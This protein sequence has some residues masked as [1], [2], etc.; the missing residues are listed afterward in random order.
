MYEHIKQ[1]R[2]RW[3]RSWTHS[4]RYMYMCAQIRI[5]VRDIVYS[6]CSSGYP[7]SLRA[8]L[9]RGIPTKHK[10][11]FARCQP[12]LS[13]G[14]RSGYVP[15][16]SSSTSVHQFWNLSLFY[17]FRSQP[18]PPM[19]LTALLSPVSLPRIVSLHFF[20]KLIENEIS[21]SI[22]FIT[23]Q[24]INKYRRNRFLDGW[25]SF[26]VSTD[27]ILFIIFCL[28]QYFYTI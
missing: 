1:L 9:D 11:V 24:N 3:P 25:S 19:P 10:A 2:Y 17:W 4:Y 16:L 20:C 26:T 18:P 7:W 27:L 15:F 23:E 13:D 5:Y 14:P 6:S 8:R 12:P 21:A 22:W 28:Q